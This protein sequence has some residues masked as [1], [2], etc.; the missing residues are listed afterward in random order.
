MTRATS[1]PRWRRRHNQ[2]EEEAGR[3]RVIE[4]V[5]FGASTAK[6][7]TLQELGGAREAAGDTSIR[8]PAKTTRKRADA[9]VESLKKAGGSS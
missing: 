5:P 9:V 6:D 1:A 3:R 4:A 2:G 8:S 7:R